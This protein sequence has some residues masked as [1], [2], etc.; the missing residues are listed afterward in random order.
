MIPPKDILPPFT[1]SIQFLHSTKLSKSFHVYNYNPAPPSYLRWLLATEKKKEKKKKKR[2]R[3]KVFPLNT[4]THTHTQ[5]K[6]TPV[7]SIAPQD[8]LQ[9]PRLQLDHQLPCAVTKT[10]GTFSSPPLLRPPPH[11]F[12][13]RDHKKRGQPGRG[14]GGKGVWRRGEGGRDAATAASLILTLPLP[15][16]MLSV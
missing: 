12:Q 8:I 5:E 1:Q 2:K 9:L 6:N 10:L 3:K 15:H 7:V 14:K 4:H 13:R 11:T 16:H